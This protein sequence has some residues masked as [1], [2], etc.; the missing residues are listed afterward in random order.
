MAQ[1][2]Q[3]LFYL[4]FSSPN[5]NNWNKGLAI[6]FKTPQMGVSSLQK[7]LFK[8]KEQFAYMLQRNVHIH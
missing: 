1:S 8:I 2:T 4:T 3:R 6:C 7:Y 5:K